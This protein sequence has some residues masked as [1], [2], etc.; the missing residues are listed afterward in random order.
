MKKIIFILTILLVGCSTHRKASNLQNLNKQASDAL[1]V[2]KGYQPIDPIPLKIESDVEGLKFRDIISEFPN[3]ATRLAIGKVNQSGALTFGPFSVA[4]KGETYSVIVDY[5]K[6]ITTAIPAVYKENRTINKY[7][8]YVKNNY[9]Y[10][11]KNKGPENIPDKLKSKNVLISEYTLITNHGAVQQFTAILE[12]PTLSLQSNN[13]LTHEVRIPVYVGIGLRIQATVTVLDDS[14]NLGS[15]YGLGV[16]AAQNRV[17]GSLIIQTLGISGEN[18]SPILPISGRINESTIQAAMQS[19]ATIKSNI[20]D[21][22]T[23]ITPQVVAFGLPYSI[24]GSKA[25]IESTLHTTPPMLKI[26]ESMEVTL[27]RIPSSIE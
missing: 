8:D 3:E 27:P 19:L 12:N 22:K 17:R 23:H 10:L 15:F 25:L 6:Y 20:Y 2:M 16:A 26:T 24:N 13:E 18:I 5:I 21:S 4:T 11:N 14:V 7:L 1:T 9:N